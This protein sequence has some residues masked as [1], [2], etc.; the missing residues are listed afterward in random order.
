MQFDEKRP[1]A[2]L[3]GRVGGAG[4]EIL[5]IQPILTYILHHAKN[6]GRP[7]LRVSVLSVP[8]LGLLDSGASRT[9]LGEKGLNLLQRLSLPLFAGGTVV[10]VS[11]GEKCESVGSLS[12]PISVENKVILLDVLVVPKLPHF[13]I[14]GIDFWRKCGIVPDLRGDQWCF[15]DRPE[16]LCS[17]QENEGDVL[18]PNERIL[19][20][21]E[22]DRNAVLM[23]NSLGCTTVAEH[24][25]RTNSE[26]IRQRYYRVSPIMQKYIDAELD[27]MLRLGVVEKSSSPWASSIVMV[28]KAKSDSWRFC[29]DFRKLN[30]VTARDSYPL[31]IL[32]DVL[33][34]LRDARYLSTLDIKSAYWQVPM[35]KNSRQYTAFIVPT[36]GLFQFTRMPFG[37]HN[38]PA[39][40]QRLIDKILGNLEPFVFVYL[41]DVV[42]CTQTFEKHLEVLEEVFRRLREAQLT[43][44][45]DKCHFCKPNMKYL[46]FVIDRKGLHVNPDKIKSMFELPPPQNVK[47]V[48]RIIGRFSWYRRFVP[49]FSTIVSPI[50]ALIKKCSK[51]VW[52]PECDSAFRRIKELLI[53]APVLSCPDYSLPFVIQTDASGYG[54]GAVLVQ[55]HHDGDSVICFLSRSLTKQERNYTTTERECL[56]VLWSIEKLRCYIEGVPFTLVTDHYS[57]VWL[58]NLREL[59]GL[60][61]SSSSILKLSIGRAKTMLFR[62]CF[63]GR[64]P[65]LMRWLFLRRG[66]A[67]LKTVG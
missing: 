41:D 54:I 55:P 39:T 62:T 33:D 43:V 67:S 7:Y 19:L 52:T 5:A 20:K 26:P 61:V 3:G 59:G 56:A 15:V 58:Q 11:N 50:T 51:F 57:L 29:V 9:F 48:R 28:K 2:P 21:E 66:M 36:R 32:A 24:V 38:A 13:L 17:L 23:G 65:L 35:E 60:F 1:A 30:S 27:E 12:L 4:R 47:E 6:D 63:L 64:F 31:P 34:K 10:A 14:L 22:V 16:S 37:L 40:W 44:S 49:E 25:I 8:L 42:I 46:G 53:R 45:F 18:C